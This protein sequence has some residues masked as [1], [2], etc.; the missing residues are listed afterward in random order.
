MP[1]FFI[2][3]K[4]KGKFE[5][6]L[7]KI[8]IQLRDYNRNNTALF[9]IITDGPKWR[10]YY[11]LTAGEFSDKCYKELDIAKDDFGDLEN[12]FKE[13]LS[14]EAVKSGTAEEQAK[15][16]L[17]LNRN[18]RL[19]SDKLVLAKKKTEEFPFPSLPDAL[20]EIMKEM[21]LHVTR[22][23]A[24]LFLKKARSE[25]ENLQLNKGSS[26]TPSILPVSPYSSNQNNDSIDLSLSYN[27]RVS[28]AKFQKV[29]GKITILKGSLANPIQRIGLSVGQ[30]KLRNELIMGKTLIQENNNL[31]TKDYEFDSPA[32]AANVIVGGSINCLIYWKNNSGVFLRD[33]Q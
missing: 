13:F 1:S 19:M 23:E 32:Y 14:L 30:E 33:L 7:K 20:C 3:V 4:N 12:S 6:D 22:E 5:N 16:Y 28:K 9:S 31:F 26:P 29:T 25:D 10:F 27:G 21:N 8:E 17:Q 24:V 15:E 18:Q 2:E 11:S